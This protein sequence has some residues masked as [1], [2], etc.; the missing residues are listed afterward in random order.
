VSAL[1][2]L[3]HRFQ[4]YLLAPQAGVVDD[5]IVGDELANARFRLNIYAQAYRLRLIEVLA[6]NDPALHTLLGDGQF[7]ALAR[8][9]IDAHTST[10]PSIRWYGA[11]MQDFLACTDPWQAQPLLSEMAAFEWALRAAFDAADAPPATIESL[12]AVDPSAWPVMRLRFHASVARMDLQWNTPAVWKAVDAGEDPPEPER[13]GNP[14]AWVIWR[15]DLRQYFRSLSVDEAWAL[16]AARLGRPFEEVCE[17]LCE[18]I[19]TG[20][21]ALHAAGLI[22]RW[23]ADGLIIGVEA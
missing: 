6:D 21:V 15:R 9:Y 20:H 2:E 7:D 19:D 11:A 23:V 17:G 3:Q 8:A 16:D 1:R 14:V 12:A 18:W 22:K 13:A 5:Q 10:H 4:D